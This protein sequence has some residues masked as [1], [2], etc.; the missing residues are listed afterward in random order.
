MKGKILFLAV[1]V[2]GLAGIHAA[3]NPTGLTFKPDFA[4]T[5]STLG[6]WKPA[7]SAKWQAQDGKITSQSENAQVGVLSSEVKLQDVALHF[8]FRA[9][10]N[11]EVGVLL[12]FEPTSDGFKGL[13]ISAKNGEVEAYDVNFDSRLVET[14]RELLRTIGNDSLVRIAPL[15]TARREPGSRS[16][17]R[18]GRSNDADKPLKR[19]DT[20][21]RTNDWNQLEVFLDANIIRAFLNDGSLSTVGATD[22]GGFGPIAFY[23]AG[24]GEAHFKNFVFRDAAL[25]ELPREVSSPHFKV[26]R[27]NDMFY[28]WA[29]AAAD[30][31]RD[32]QMDVVAGPY[33]YFGPD[34]TR[35]REIFPATPLNPARIFPEIN[36]QYAFDANGDGWPD[37]LTGPPR[38]TLYLNPKNEPRRWEKSVAVPQIQSEI[39]V[40]KDIDGSGIPALVYCADGTL[41]FAKPD[42]QNPTAAWKE[43]IISEKGFAMAHGIG[44]GDINGDGRIDIVNPHGWWEQPAANMADSLWAYHPA[45]LARYGHRSSG[46]GGATMGVYDVNGDGSNDVVTSLNAHGFGLAWFEQKRDATGAVSF[47]CHMIADDYAS[48]NAGG[49][50]FS[51]A[52]GTTFADLD[53]DGVLDFIVGKRYWSH[54]D[55]YFDPDP[56]GPPVLYCF[57]T[58][59]NPKVPGGAEFLPELIHNRSG[60]GSDILA[61]DLNGDGTIDV[62]TSTDRGTFVFWNHFGAPAKAPAKSPPKK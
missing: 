3:E 28:S 15:D 55:S 57:R 18:D 22:L 32:G 53:G 16:S 23:R 40:L 58:K 56:Y 9:S 21:F 20:S 39:T 30:F 44:A 11:V 61:A 51:Q 50:T 2:L 37:V 59:R 54:L 47:A 52:H 26:Q 33:I 6:S 13:L 38:A 25:R 60:A 43:H 12:R 5:G 10:A 4:F 45:A 19:P 36:C 27:L 41:R 49:V 1:L 46:V 7:G 34:F 14:R 48:T 31:D 24:A 62:A 8:E 17:R 35:S 29:A 42:P